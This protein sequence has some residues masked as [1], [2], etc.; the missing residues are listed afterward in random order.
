MSKLLN[1]TVVVPIGNI[2]VNE[3]KVNLINEKVIKATKASADVKILQLIFQKQRV[4][5]LFTDVC[6]VQ[7][8]I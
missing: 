7:N 6:I 1:Y 3:Q 8:F 4:R 5:E 2:K